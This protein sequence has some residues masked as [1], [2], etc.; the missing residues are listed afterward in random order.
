MKRTG[1]SIRFTPEEEADLA[2]IAR[3]MKLD[4]KLRRL[5]RKFGRTAAVCYAIGHIIDHPPEHVGAQG[6]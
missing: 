2:K 4:P 3:W 6:G 5:K 1:T